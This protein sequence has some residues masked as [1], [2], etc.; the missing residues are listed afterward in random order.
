M[1]I[2][3]S[4]ATAVLFTSACKQDERARTPPASGGEAH[5]KPVEPAP[6]R[7][8]L[9]KLHVELGG[10]PM[11]MTRAFVKRLPPDRYQVYV[12]SEDGACEHLIDNVFPRVGP[13]PAAVLVDVTPRLGAD[14][15]LA[16]TVTSVYLLGGPVGP[17]GDAAAGATA[18]IT[19]NG[20]RGTTTQ[21]ELDFTAEVNGHHVVV[22][23]AFDAEGC[24]ERPV[25]GPIDGAPKATH[26][27]TATLTIAGKQLPIRGAI[28]AGREVAPVIGAPKVR[29]LVLSTG[30]KDC[31]STTPWAEVVVTRVHGFWR[32]GGTWFDREHGNNAL[33]DDATKRVFVK[34]GA[35]GNSEDGPTVQLDLSGEGKI[36]D[37]PVALAGTIEALDCP[38]SATVR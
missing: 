5:A 33:P 14:G 23:G 26:A 18:K 30:P 2:I 34:L 38:V 37:Y 13:S 7:K 3:V 6:G 24:G 19:G 8:L 16:S 22:R 31:S 1:R 20:D 9:D 27:S 29:D 10:K 12:T 28:L 11:P 21:I 15:G 35:K 17:S 4:I 32:V 25:T 36:G